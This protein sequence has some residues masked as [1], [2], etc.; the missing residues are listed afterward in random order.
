[1]F[2]D[3]SEHYNE[4]SLTMKKLHESKLEADNDYDPFARLEKYEQ[5]VHK[6]GL[7][8]DSSYFD[9]KNRFL[10][11]RKELELLPIVICHNDSQPSNFIK[12]DAG[13]MLLVD[14]EFG[15]NNDFIYDIACFG[16]NDFKYAI[17]IL[18]VYLGR[19][20]ER[21]EWKRLYLWRVFQCLQWHNVALYKEATGLSQELQLDFK[22]I[23]ANYIA[24]ANNLFAEALKWL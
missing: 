23:A 18:P 21:H 15:G 6:A 20:P 17:G 10:V 7:E 4:A 13:G 5:L 19:D 1:M 12:L 16:N 22:M 14:W 3:P 8:H 2:L 11:F 24:K 9:I